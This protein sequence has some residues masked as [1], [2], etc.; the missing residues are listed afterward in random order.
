MARGAPPAHRRPPAL[1]WWREVAYIAVFYAVYS[2]IRNEGVATNSVGAAFR[3][4]RQV[5]NLERLLGTYH[6]ETIQD[7]FLPTEWFV[8]FW[9]VFYGT[10]HFVVTAGV[11]IWLFRRQPERYPLWRNTLAATTALAL[12]GF[13]LYPLMPPRLL[14]AS[15]GYVDTLEAIGGLWS[16]DSGPVAKVSNQYAAMPSLHAA[17][18]TWCALAVAPALRSAP[19]RWAAAAYPLMTLF[20]VVVTANHFWLDAAGGLLVLGVGFLVGRAITRSQAARRRHPVR[21]PVVAAP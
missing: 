2:F 3:H 9:N 20:A 16:F 13:A 15:Y 19:A 7:W 6:E 17:W 5:I 4:A 11:L 8:S 18:A 10:A 12:V 21:R 1:R 14:P